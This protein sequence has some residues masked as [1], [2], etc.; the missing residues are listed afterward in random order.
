MKQDN[1]EIASDYIVMMNRCRDHYFH[2]ECLQGQLNSNEY[3]E[4][5]TCKVMYGIKT[6]DQPK[7]TMSWSLE[8]FACDGFSSDVKTWVIQYEFPSGINPETNEK[9][10]GD[11][12][13]G[14]IPD[15]EEGRKVLALFVECF[16]R[17]LTFTVGFSVVRG[18]DNCIVWNGVHH[19]TR[20]HGGST[21]YGYPDDTYLNRVQQ[22]MALKG[23]VFHDE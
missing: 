4:C 23:V 15:T 22:E 17:R 7:G 9:F 11:G 20:T 14:F 21:H 2:L 8:A 18:R 1:G 6:G 13:T 10:H 16:R 19:K 3:L 12:R 5:S